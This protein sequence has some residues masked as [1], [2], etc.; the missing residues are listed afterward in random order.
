[1]RKGRGFN[2]EAAEKIRL[3]LMVYL[4]LDS[5][6]KLVEEYLLNGITK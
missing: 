4:V 3:H 2:Q 1:M 5:A 6:Y